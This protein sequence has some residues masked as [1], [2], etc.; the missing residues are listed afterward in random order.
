MP[1]RGPASK[2]S[3]VSSFPA[4]ASLAAGSPG[5]GRDL[6]EAGRGPPAEG[7]GPDAVCGAS[8]ES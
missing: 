4:L 7:R 5:E 3:L 6:E 2:A 8:G 1:G